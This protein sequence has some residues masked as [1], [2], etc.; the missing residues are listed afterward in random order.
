M[1]ATEDQQNAADFAG[2]GGPDAAEAE[3]AEERMAERISAARREAGYRT[4]QDFAE[5]LQVSVWTVRSWESGKSQP[6]YDVLREI[7]RLTRRP[8][9][10]FLG[11]NPAQQ[12]VERAMDQILERYRI[13]LKHGGE[14]DASEAGVYGLAPFDAAAERQLQALSADARRW[15]LLLRLTR[16]TAPAT[17][18]ELAAL[19]LTLAGLLGGGE[20]SAPSE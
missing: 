17:A 16:P 9:A 15:G 5:D 18:D 1:A 12:D 10:W 19:H 20:A 3:A 13:R 2:E 7:S 4:A 6:R 11:E 14:S 8:V